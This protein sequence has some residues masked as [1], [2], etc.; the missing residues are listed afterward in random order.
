[1]VDNCKEN[2]KFGYSE[3]VITSI[4]LIS[5][6]LNQYHGRSLLIP[7]QVTF[8]LKFQCYRSCISVVY[9]SSTPNTHSIGGINKTFYRW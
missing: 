8:S 3:V 2:G 7:P 4:L 5:L 9:H 1:M 6:E